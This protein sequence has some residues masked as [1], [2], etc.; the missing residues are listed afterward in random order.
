MNEVCRFLNVVFHI[1]LEH[2]Q[3]TCLIDVYRILEKI[4]QFLGFGAIWIIAKQFLE[5]QVTSCVIQQFDKVASKFGLI[6]WGGLG[7]V[8]HFAV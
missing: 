3:E 1:G 5:T 6:E 2:K 8:Q 7:F 4:Q